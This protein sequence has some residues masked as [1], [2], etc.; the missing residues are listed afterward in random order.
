[1]IPS[2]CNNLA[3]PKIDPFFCGRNVLCIA[4]TIYLCTYVYMSS[5][6]FL[7]PMKW[8]VTFTFRLPDGFFQTK[9]PNLGKFWRVLQW[10]IL[11]YFMIIWSISRPFEIF[12][13]HLVYFVVIWYIFPHF[14]YFVPRK[15][16]QPWLK[17]FAM[18]KTHLFCKCSITKD[19]LEFP[20]Q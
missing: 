4:C 20:R 11:V 17:G 18:E 13:G 16:W 3:V 6:I 19:A 10:K 12:C 1:M 14:W 9:N 5:P 8:H 7:W 2:C 15:I